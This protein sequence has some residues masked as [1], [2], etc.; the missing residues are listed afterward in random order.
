MGSKTKS[1]Q[2][3]SG[4]SVR[5]LA[6]GALLGAALSSSAVRTL[7]VGRVGVPLAGFVQSRWRGTPGDVL[8]PNTYDYE[9]IMADRLVFEVKD[10][11]GK[12]KGAVAAREIKRGE[13]IL[14]EHPLLLAPDDETPRE[15]V[16]ELFYNWTFSPSKRDIFFNLAHWVEDESINLDPATQTPDERYQLAVGTIEVNVAAVSVGD[17]SYRA[18]FPRFSRLNHACPGANNVNYVWREDL[19]EMRLYAVRDIPKGGEFG[20]S[21]IHKLGPTADR[22]ET[23]KN[24][25]GFTCG[26][27]FCTQDAEA[28]AQRDAW[29]A[30]WHA[31]EKDF[32]ERSEAGT[33]PGPEAIRIVRDLWTVSFKLDYTGDRARFSEEAALVALAHGDTKSA[34]QWLQLALKYFSIEVGADGPDADRIRDLLAY[35]AGADGFGTKERLTLQGPDAAWFDS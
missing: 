8:D 1:S 7:V 32:D 26:C 29:A 27:K 24:T 28:T 10:L 18:L 4:V 5:S 23:L 11:P 9:G 16:H 3:Q 31:L 25:W 30:E 12:G 17:T 14:R 19:R 2:K 13:L 35:P 20:G 34:E 21:Y 6:L 33:L 22:I 15:W